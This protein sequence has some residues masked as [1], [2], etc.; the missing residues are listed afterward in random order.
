MTEP[1]APRFHTQERTGYCDA[2]HHKFPVSLLCPIGEGTL[3][4]CPRC[5]SEAQAVVRTLPRKG[6]RLVR[7]A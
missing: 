4:A 6:L 5:L 7:P 1:T 3:Q 2:C